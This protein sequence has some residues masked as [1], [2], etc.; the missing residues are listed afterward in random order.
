MLQS[1]TPVTFPGRSWLAALLV[2]LGLLPAARAAAQAPSWDWAI[3]PGVGF[4]SRTVVDRAGNVYVAGSFTGTATF[5]ATTL[6]SAASS[7]D[8][9]VAKLNP[10]GTYQWAVGV[11]SAEYEFFSDLAVDPRGN[12]YVTGNFRSDSLSFGPHLVRHVSGDDVFVAKLS[13]A[14]AWE[15]ATAACNKTYEG[16]LPAVAPQPG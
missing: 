11:G 15:W 2:V 10:T 6:T 9:F 14:G 4:G 16:R 5:G 7:Y 1:F 13:A 3:T 8:V 12:V